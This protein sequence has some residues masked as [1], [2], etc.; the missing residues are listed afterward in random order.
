MAI[1]QQKYTEEQIEQIEAL[2]RELLGI[3]EELNSK[4][5]AMNAKLEN[6]EKKVVHLNYKLAMLQQ[7]IINKYED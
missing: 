5:I 4:I 2:V 1:H 7:S 3:N 6:E